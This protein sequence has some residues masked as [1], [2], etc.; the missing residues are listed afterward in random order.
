LV[1]G[2]VLVAARLGGLPGLWVMVAFA[3][4]LA[5]TV[6]RLRGLSHVLPNLLRVGLMEAALS[7]WFLVWAA[8]A[9]R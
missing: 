8:A 6:V 2:L 5:R 3:P 1:C 7:A 4:A 9:L